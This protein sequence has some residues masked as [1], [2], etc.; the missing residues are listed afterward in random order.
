VAEGRIIRTCSLIAAALAACAFAV[1]AIAEQPARGSLL[2]TYLRARADDDAGRLEAAAAGYA[3][4][5]AS[6][7]T[8]VD[9]AVRTMRQAVEA[10]DRVLAVRT[11][12]AIAPNRLPADGKLLL[13]VDAIASKDWVGAR[14]RTQAIGPDD[15][16]S[17]VAPTL[18]AWIALG[19]KDPDPL[20]PLA[21]APPDSLAASYTGEHRALLLLA[22][23]KT[24]EGIDALRPW[25]AEG[26]GRA[27]RLALIGAVA[28]QRA[29]K[30]DEAIALLAGDNTALAAARA[31]LAAGAS[32]PGGIA[33]AAQGSAELLIRIAA[34]MYHQKPSRVALLP[35][36]MA[37]FLDPASSEVWLVISNML[38]D[39]GQYPP[40]LAVLERISPSDPFAAGARDARLQLLATS[41]AKDQALAEA[42]R[43]SQSPQADVGDWTRLGDI[44]V[45]MDRQ[46][47]AA[48]AYGHAITVAKAGSPDRDLWSLWMLRGGALER[49]GNWAEAEPA[50]RKAL[51]LAPEQ[52]IVLNYLGYAL[53]ERRQNITE[54]KALVEKASRLAPDDSA[55]TDSVGYA[56]YLQGNYPTAIA[57][58]ERA[59]AGDPGESSINEHLGDAYW[60]VG[61]RLEARFAWT[62]AMVEAE[63]ADLTRLRAKID[64]GGPATA[65]P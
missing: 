38:G 17:F 61:R 9:L 41:G 24:K 29:G 39:A 48:E 18:K 58:F 53:L 33:D 45:E 50:L 22:M 12:K 44:L 63:P 30:R 65:Q 60:A 19:A 54:A 51:A 52:P 27:T 43:A 64:N 57:T 59:V 28:L 55:I 62:A 25:L 31:R 42:R 14:A 1:P 47:E 36:R 23:G 13:V 32:L 4:V 35:A 21:A 15:P 10:G 6:R 7:P 46:A 34:D 56:A 26:G 37:S 20:A 3:N 11:A 49:A 2:D 40:A 16:F 8:D 5:L